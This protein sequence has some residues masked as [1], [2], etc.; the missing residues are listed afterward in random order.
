MKTT[1]WTVMERVNGD[2]W[3]AVGNKTSERAAKLLRTRLRGDSDR[4]YQIIPLTVAGG[5]PG[6]VDV[7]P[8][9]VYSP[10]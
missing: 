7:A 1:V 4:D 3:I 5:T 8:E 10:K 2:E 6:A 9:L